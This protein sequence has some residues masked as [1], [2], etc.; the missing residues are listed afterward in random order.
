MC[1]AQQGTGQ[2]CKFKII[3]VLNVPLRVMLSE[4]CHYV[5]GEN[6]MAGRSDGEKAESTFIQ[7][8]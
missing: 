4:L 7:P 6:R 1:A 5:N 8:F 2:N 3:Y